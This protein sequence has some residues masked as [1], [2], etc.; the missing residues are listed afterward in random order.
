[1]KHFADLPGD[2]SRFPERL[3]ALGTRGSAHRWTTTELAREVLATPSQHEG[4]AFNYRLYAITGADTLR[5][6]YDFAGA[7]D[8]RLAHRDVALV[9]AEKYSGLTLFE[10]GF[11]GRVII[12]HWPR[13][14]RSMFGTWCLCLSRDSGLP[15]IDAW[16]VETFGVFTE[17]RQDDVVICAGHR[18]D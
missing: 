2:S 5:G 13:S 8:R 9:I 1:M 14:I 11:T 18:L 12:S 15:M 10:M 16:N 17:L 3:E 7:Y 4:A 6:A